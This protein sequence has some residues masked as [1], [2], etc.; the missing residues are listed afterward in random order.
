[1]TS[2]QLVP[3]LI[4]PLIAWR[5]YVRVRRNIG[6]QPF[7]PKRTI[8]RIVIFSVL[9]VL[10]GLGAFG[11]LPSLAALGG[12]LLLGAPLALIGL[13]LTKFE[14]TP[15][16]KFYT[17]NTPI[18][19]ALSVLFVG[20]VGYRF[21]VLMTVPVVNGN[22][23]PALFHSPLTLFIFGL[24]AGYY[25]AYYAGVLVHGGKLA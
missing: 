6:R 24:T 15:Q 8:S 2:A 12:G 14:T 3:A 5:V 25:I 17:P 4:V 21:F 23:T 10:V 7:Q 22:P 19:V 13:H 20:R 11:Y 1:M 18:G 16:G 9:S